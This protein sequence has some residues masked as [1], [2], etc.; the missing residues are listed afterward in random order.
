MSQTWYRLFIPH[1][2]SAAITDAL[3]TVLAA[4]GYNPYDPFPGGTGTPIG[5]TEMVKLFVAPPEDEWITVLG[6]FP[7]ESLLDLH[8]ALDAPVIYGYLTDDSG[9]FVLFADGT[10]YDDPAAFEPYKRA[11]VTSDALQDAFAGKLAVEAIEGEG[12]PVMAIGADSLPPEIRQ[13]AED[14]GADP[15]Q[16]GKLFEKM[17]G[18]LFKRMSKQTGA[19][20]D[21]QAQAQAMFMGGGQ[22]AWN[23]L[24]GQRVRAIISV[25][26]L[27]DNWRTPSQDAI[28]DAYQVFRLRQRAPRMPLMPGDKEAMD[29]VPDALD[30]T[31]V[32]MGRT[33]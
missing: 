17:S 25:L 21:E 22:D 27:P 8:Q 26:T 13:L 30:H 5:L 19:T 9:G 11:S 23:S 16:A 18:K 1:T 29:A 32:Y 2:D 14:Q 4:Q 33:S 20:R 28:R 24:N 31:P 12:P 3:R 6:Q 7:E 15:A 10:R